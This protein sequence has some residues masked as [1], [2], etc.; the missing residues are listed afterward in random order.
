[1]VLATQ[2]CFGTVNA[3]GGV[4]GRMLR[5]VT[6]DDGDRL[7]AS[8]KRVQRLVYMQSVKGAQSTLRALGTDGVGVV[9]TAVEPFPLEPE[10]A[11]GARVP[12][13]V[14]EGARC[15]SRVVHR[16]AGLYQ[17]QGAARRAALRG[18]RPEPVARR[19]GARVA[20]APGHRGG[21]A[22][23]GKGVCQGPKFLDLTIIG[24][25]GKFAR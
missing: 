3:Q 1:M 23:Y 12:H 7:D 25:G 9:V 18:A 14:R 2:A 11:R 22:D 19:A 13:C 16:L 17:C 21:E 10:P 8:V 15:G 20:A 5:A 24:A 6:F 4:L